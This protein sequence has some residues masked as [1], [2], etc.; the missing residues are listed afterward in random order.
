VFGI[1]DTLSTSLSS[2]LGILLRKEGLPVDEVM[3]K[4]ES[5]QTVFCSSDSPTPYSVTIALSLLSSIVNMTS[6]P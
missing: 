1:P 4:A 5:L 6:F 2:N 3:Q